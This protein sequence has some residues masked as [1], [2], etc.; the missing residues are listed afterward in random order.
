MKAIG[1]IYL[2]W[3]K[4]RGSKRITIGVIKNNIT[5]G[6]RFNYIPVKVKEA[7]EYG[8][9]NYEGFPEIDKLYSENVLEKFGQRLIQSDR[10]DL[11]GFYDFWGVD[12]KYKNNKYY[13]LAHTQGILPTDNFELLADFN[14]IKGLT[15]ISEIT[16]LKEAQIPSDIIELGDKLSYEL[17]K[18]N[19]FDKF[20][21][22]L[23]KN[24]YY[25]GHIKLIHNKVFHKSK[26]PLNVNVH[27]IEK[28]GVLNKVFIKIT[29]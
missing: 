9:V 2:S 20:A 15:F 1:N 8:F 4:G 26:Y 29:I 23:F 13:M 24:N 7:K 16:N 6:V 11:K 5:D 25:L 14:P 17:E 12:V 27:S 28:N 3:R 18:K 22:K 21:V 10:N 19:N